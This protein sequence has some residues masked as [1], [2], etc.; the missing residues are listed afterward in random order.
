MCCARVRVLKARRT[1]G[2]I[3]PGGTIASGADLAIA[4][5]TGTVAGGGLARGGGL[6]GSGLGLTLGGLLLAGSGGGLGL[7]SLLAL[8]GG[9]GGGGRGGG[10]GGLLLS[11]GGLGGT[12][13]TEKIEE[14]GSLDSVLR[15]CLYNRSKEQKISE[16][17]KPNVRVCSSGGVGIA[18]V[19]REQL[20]R[21][22]NFTN[23]VPA[24]RQ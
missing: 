21:W 20:V 24:W 22:K 5:R 10:V 16:N 14:V 6:T 2:G 4:G 7:L 17:Y 19:R 9:G 18:G 23:Q 12:L 15:H 8:L 3:P 11:G 1:G 13:L